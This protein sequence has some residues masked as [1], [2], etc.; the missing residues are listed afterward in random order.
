MDLQPAAYDRNL[1][2]DQLITCLLSGMAC[3]VDYNWWGHSIC[4]ADAVEIDSSLP[5]S[6]P[7]RWGVRIWNSWADT[8]GKLGMAVLRG[9][10]AIPDGAT[11]IS[12][13]TA[14]EN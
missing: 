7:N 9:N 11:A 8:Y 1:S 2:L 12:V 5:L 10:K 4:A 3:P 6:D 13:V 14:T